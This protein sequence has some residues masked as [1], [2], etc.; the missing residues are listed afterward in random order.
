MHTCR[1]DKDGDGAINA[2]ELR[3]VLQDLGCLQERPKAGRLPSIHAGAG[4]A[5]GS[6]AAAEDVVAE[7]LRMADT[8]GDGVLSFE[9][10]CA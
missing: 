3:Q 8:D 7:Q 1:Y 5:V 9:E 10:F 4:A 2:A 6:S